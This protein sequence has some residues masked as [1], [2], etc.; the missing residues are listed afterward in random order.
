[1]YLSWNL[2]LIMLKGAQRY[3]TR[4]QTCTTGESSENLNR[5]KCLC[6]ETLEQKKI[7]TD[8]ALYFKLAS[9]N[10]ETRVNEIFRYTNSHRGRS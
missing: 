10:T 2:T 7:K 6:T 8:L 5:I 3:F 9:G 4:R 1:M